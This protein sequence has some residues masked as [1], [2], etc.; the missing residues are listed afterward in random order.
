MLLGLIGFPLDHSWS[1]KFF[2]EKFRVEGHTDLKYK[3]FPLIS[4]DEFPP[5]LANYPELSGLNVTLPYKEKILPYLDELDETSHR[6][7]AVNAI[8]IIRENGLIRT[9]GFNTDSDGF[10]LTLKDQITKCNALI[11]GTGGSSKAVAYA[12]NKLNIHFTFVSRKT[13]GQDIISY[14]ELTVDIIMNNKLIINATPVGMYPDNT[15]CPRIPYQCLTKDHFL[16][17]L[18]YN[19]EETAFIKQGK[20]MNTRTMNGLQMLI[21]QA[22]LSFEI[23]RTTA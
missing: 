6:I 7:G 11:L 10:Y 3:L 17:D 8:K 1:A 20:K 23:F 2:K 18:V 22:E 21:N 13:S 12:L 14:D 15:H 5:L 4:L 19:P 9:K 16:Y